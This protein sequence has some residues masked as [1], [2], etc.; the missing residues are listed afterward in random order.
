MIE[1]TANEF[2]AFSFLLADL[3]AHVLATPFALVVVAYAIQL[4]A[5]GPP[6]RERPRALVAELLLAALLLGSLYAINSFDF[7]TAGAIVLAA[8]AIWALDGRRRLGAAGAWALGVVLAAVLLFLPFWLHFSPPTKGIAL[9]P[10][11]SKFSQFLHD[12]W[13]IYGLFAWI[14]LAAFAA[15][16]RMPRRY[17]AWTGAATLFLLVLLSPPRLAGLVVALT[18]AAFA[19]F[20]AFASGAVSVPYRFLWLLLAVALAL[21]ASGELVYVRDVFEGT[22]SFRFNT[23]FKTGYQAWYLLA[24]VAGVGV[25]WS[26]DWLGR[27]M[28]V[29]W[30]C[31]LAVL[32]C[33]GLAYPLAA[34]YSRS[35]GFERSP[36]LDGMR[37]LEDAA[38]ADAAAIRWLRRA[39]AG[40]PTILE[41]VGADFDPEGR[42]RVST[43]TGLPALVQWPGHEVQ[44]GHE[45][46]VRARDADLIYRTTDPRV[47]APLL[48]RYDVG[49]VFVGS[50]ERGQ[51]PQ[52][53]LDKFGR[54]GTVAFRSGRTVVYRIA[55]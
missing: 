11:H 35:A 1:G 49:L 34:G 15:R 21:L 33:L 31:G 50:L 13:S 42:G 37:W 48:A 25:F 12:Y 45:P 52:R 7:P 32:V 44:W 10:D 8:L 55:A 6:T 24:I 14:A 19:W 26:R 53:A 28:R 41:A 18:M 36:T 46:G 2:P 16:L 23:V 20:V 51:Y 40:N 47:A 29:G 54:I 39:I 4:A 17:L 22:P 27:R 43:F 3:H 9:V 38:P 30:L 5:S